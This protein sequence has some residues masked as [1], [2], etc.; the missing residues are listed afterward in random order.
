MAWRRTWGYLV[1]RLGIAQTEDHARILLGL[2]EAGDELRLVLP[3]ERSGGFKRQAC[4][5]AT[6]YS[7]RPLPGRVAGISAESVIRS[8]RRARW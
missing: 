8:L 6:C 2:E 5:G 1:F 7:S 4:H 3:D